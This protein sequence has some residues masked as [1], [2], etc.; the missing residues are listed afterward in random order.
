MSDTLF[1]TKAPGI[2][3]RLM[4]DFPALAADPANPAAIVGNLGHECAGFTKLQEISPT[5]HG[6]RGGYGWAQWTGPRRR[7]Y[8][9]WCRQHG[10]EPSSDEANYGYLKT[11]LSGAYKSAVAAVARANGLRA[12]VEA[13]ERIY[14]GA[15]VKAY[16][17]RERWARVA[18]EAFNQA[19]VPVTPISLPA[20]D[21][22][23]VAGPPPQETK[24][25][26]WFAGIVAAVAA[27][28]AAAWQ[29]LQEWLPEILIGIVVLAV[30]ILL[31]FRLTKGRWPWTGHLSL[32]SLPVSLPSSAGSSAQ[33]LVAH[34]EALRAP[35]PVTP[36]PAPSASPRTRQRSRTRSAA[37]RKPK[38][39]SKS[40]KRNTRMR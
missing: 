11:E 4:A 37:T 29:F 26:G 18:L 33:A 17:S 8:E 13:F 21:K 23:A 12:K 39:R 35:S 16:D 28:L 40:S 34:L 22:P 6:S 36:L 38:P 10:L 14:E 2:M 27:A 15:G 7:E 32:P 31:I 19:A 20:P 5:V 3:R 9:A 24:H 25:D 1:R 30:L